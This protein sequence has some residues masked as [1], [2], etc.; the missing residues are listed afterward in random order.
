MLKEINGI[1]KSKPEAKLA[2]KIIQRNKPKILKIEG[3]KTDNAIINYA[4]KN[5]EAIIATLDREIKKKI[6]NPKIVIRN[7]KKLEII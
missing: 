2:L 7:K 1:T 4:K 5:P 3:K 6:Q